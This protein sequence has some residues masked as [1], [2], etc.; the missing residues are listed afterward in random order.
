MDQLSVFEQQKRLYSVT[1][2]NTLV[3]EIIRELGT[4]RVQGE[5]TELSITQNKG[6][7][8]TLS[9]GKSNLRVGG[10]APGIKGIDLVDKDMKVIVEGRADLY[11]PYGTFSLAATSVEPVGEGALAIAYQKLKQKLQ[12]EGLFADEHKQDMPQFVVKIALLTGKDSAAYSDFTKILRENAAAIEIDYYPVIVQ[13][14]NSVQNISAALQTAMKSDAQIIVLTR[15]G[16]SLEDLKSFNDEVLARMIF[17]SPKVVIVGVG[18]EKDESICDFVSDIR[19]STPSQAAYYLAE[20]N[21]MFL[22]SIV[23]HGTTIELALTNYVSD[24]RYKAQSHFSLIARSLSQLIE[25]YLQ[26]LRTYEKML[27]FTLDNLLSWYIQKVDGLER[28]LKSYDTNTILKRGFAVLQRN[29]KTIRTITDV[30]PHD[31]VDT[32]LCDGKVTSQVTN[33]TPYQ[34]NHAKKR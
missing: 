27:S 17:T 31:I 32:I 34:Y 12:D 8:L 1:E 25:P 26:K 2:F 7:Y 9:D 21:N 18:H 4:F 5:I 29:G 28:A 24:R 15:G 10:Y 6:V 30:V 11:V 16:G 13:G 23:G 3:K 19:A 33:L 14:P 20:Q 22:Q